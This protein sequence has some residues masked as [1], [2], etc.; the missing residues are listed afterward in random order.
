VPE[1]I[2]IIQGFSDEGDQLAAQV[3]GVNEAI[4]ALDRTEG[5]AV[6][7]VAP[8]CDDFTAD[9][10]ADAEKVAGLTLKD[11]MASVVDRK[12][13]EGPLTVA[14]EGDT[15]GDYD[16]VVVLTRPK[17]SPEIIALSRKLDQPV[18]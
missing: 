10:K 11:A 18:V 6:D 9:F 15:T 16:L 3:L 17:P 7:L 8:L 13:E 1:K 2:A 12:S 14:S 5:L 4:I